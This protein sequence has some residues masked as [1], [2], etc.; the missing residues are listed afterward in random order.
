M[1]NY[2]QSIPAD[3]LTPAYKDELA[4]K[5][6]SEMEIRLKEAVEEVK[7]EVRSTAVIGN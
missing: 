4:L 7:R 1:L 5:V 3:V 6:L 2:L